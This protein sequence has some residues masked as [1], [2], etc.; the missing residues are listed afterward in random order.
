MPVEIVSGDIFKSDA[1]VLVV[2][3][4]CVGVMGAGLAKE[5]KRR[6]LFGYHS[7]RYMCDAGLIR[8]GAGIAHKVGTKGHP[9]RMFYY[10][11]TKDHWRYPSRLEWVESGVQTMIKQARPAGSGPFSF[12][13]P[14]LGCG[15]GGLD[16][17]DVV[18]VVCDAFE[19]T[20][21]SVKLYRPK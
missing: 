21:H 5:F 20:P 15:L 3:V 8:V 16:F 17:D 7:Y 6:Y 4:N 14:A 10:L 1:D 19:D 2:P 18:K 11:P 12:A 9:F 13:I